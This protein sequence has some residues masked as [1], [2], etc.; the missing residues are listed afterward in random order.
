MMALDEDNEKQ[1]IALRKKRGEVKASLT[2]LRKFVKEFD[3][4]EQ[5]I[6]LLEFRQEELPN[7]N[8]KFQCEIELITEEPE[9]EEEERASFEEN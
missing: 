8:K 1:M 3:H 5:S 9:R 4:N 6:S 7:I 2:R